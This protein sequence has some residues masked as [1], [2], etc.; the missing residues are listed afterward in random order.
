LHLKHDEIR[1]DDAGADFI[2]IY[3]APKKSWPVTASKQILF[4]KKQPMKKHHIDK[5]NSVYGSSD[6]YYGV[7]LRPEFAEYFSGKDCSNLMALDLGCGE[8]RY[9]LYLAA[10][11][12][13]VLA[14]DR[15]TVGIKK[16]SEKAQNK[17]LN[18]QAVAIDIAEF[19]FEQNRYDIIVAATV[20]DHLF[21]ELL[22]ETVAKIKSALK[23]GGILY[24]NVFTVLDPGYEMQKISGAFGSKNI[25]DT[26]ECMEHYFQKGE[27]KALFK[28]FDILYDY[29]GV[30]PDLSHGAPHHHGWACLL[31]KKPLESSI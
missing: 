6:N 26:A 3:Y 10:L 5:F 8:G 22:I 24:V 29:E 15:S 14:I 7:E 23:P 21:Q 25:S 30:E 16:L 11:G 27:L 28:D 2:C 13:Q 18:I 12:C 31:A 19:E 9:A 4:L 17:R 20:L 1:V